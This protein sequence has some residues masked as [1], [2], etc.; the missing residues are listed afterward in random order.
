MMESWMT[1]ALNTRWLTTISENISSIKGVSYNV[2][3]SDRG[4]VCS[5]IFTLLTM[6]S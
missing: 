6:F 4:S 1:L 5:I 2:H 3:S